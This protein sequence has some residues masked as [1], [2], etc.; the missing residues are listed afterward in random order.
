MSKYEI[1][2]AEY[3]ATMRE[4]DMEQTIREKVNAVGGRMFH[5]RDSRTARET[6]DMPDLLII[7]PGMV[8]VIELK[9]QK[10]ATTLGQREVADLM[11]TANRFMVGIVRPI[12][13]AGEYSFDQLI[14]ALDESAD[15]LS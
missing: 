14:D 11:Q 8:A 10:R 4:I 6:K 9:S 15:L 2:T 5:I 1:G 12:P 3:K 7:V 13:K